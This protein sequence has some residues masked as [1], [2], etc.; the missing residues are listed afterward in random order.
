MAKRTKRQ[1][2]LHKLEALATSTPYVPEAQAARANAEQLKIH[3]VV[4]QVEPASAR[5]PGRVEYGH[6]ILDDG[7]VIMTDRDGAPLRHRDI[8]TRVVLKPDQTAD[9]VARRL[10]R[11]LHTAGDPYNGFFSRR[12]PKGKVP[13]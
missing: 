7:A 9:M 2:V 8:P 11:E 6:Y 12:M 3:T 1:L 5:D 13:I 4:V 10:T